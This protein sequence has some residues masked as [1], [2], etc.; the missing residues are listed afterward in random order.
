MIELDNLAQGRYFILTTT[1]NAQSETLQA[2]LSLYN[3]PYEVIYIETDSVLFSQVMSVIRK[4]MDED[5]LPCVFYGRTAIG[6]YR[7]LK[8]HFLKA[9]RMDIGFG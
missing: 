6:G 8:L 1:K 7:S 4:S 2:L 9:N 5:T 3:E